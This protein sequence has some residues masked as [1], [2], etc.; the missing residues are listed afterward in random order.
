M[1]NAGVAQDLIL[2][3]CFYFSYIYINDL[4]DELSFNAKL[5]ADNT[6]F[7]FCGAECQ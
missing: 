2:R 5:F 3:P 6:F 1:V 4:A 7:V